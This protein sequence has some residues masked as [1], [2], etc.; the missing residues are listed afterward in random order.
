MRRAQL[1]LRQLGTLVAIA[2]F[3]AAS[4][5]L[6]LPR[7]HVAGSGSRAAAVAQPDHHVPPAG[8]RWS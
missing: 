5:L 3:V 6:S 7:S 4:A 2:V 8:R 1:R